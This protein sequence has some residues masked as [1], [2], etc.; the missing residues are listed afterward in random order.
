[1][2]SANYFSSTTWLQQ[3]RRC[4]FFH[5]KHCSFS[6]SICFWSVVVLTY[7]DSR[8]D[9][10]KSCQIPR[11]CQCKWLWVSSSAPGTSLGSSRSPGKILFYTG[12]VLSTVLPSLAPRLRIDDCSAIHFLHWELCDPHLGLSF[13]P[14]CSNTADVPSFTRRTALSAI[15][16]V[17]DL[18]GVDVQWFQERSSQDLPNSKELSV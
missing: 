5:S 16:F 8:T 12:I 4:P 18:C 1:M 10:H 13:R 11:N 2:E 6:H 7:N 3:Y 14:D 9:L 15:P 17:S